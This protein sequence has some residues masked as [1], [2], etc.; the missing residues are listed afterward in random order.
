L[1]PPARPT[2]SEVLLGP[3]REGLAARL[4]GDWARWVEKSWT[5]RFESMQRG[6]KRLARVDAEGGPP[7]TD[8][9]KALELASLREELHGP[10]A[11]LPFYRAAFDAHP[12]EA[13][14][15]FALG[16]VL[17]ELDR[18]EGL[19]VVRPLFDSPREAVAAA[20]HLA[21]EYFRRRGQGEE[22][23][24]HLAMALEN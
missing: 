7:T 9:R 20:H 24:R 2:A 15:R 23:C 21:C 22:A 1:P 4:D 6:A 8:P 16:R 13:P 18:E 12:G 17:L 14:L 11:A 3:A 5:D 10:E 19:E